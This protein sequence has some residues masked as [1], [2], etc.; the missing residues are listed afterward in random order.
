[1]ES[2]VRD[3]RFVARSMAR[4]PGFFITVIATLGLG[5][6]AT[7]AI[8]SVVN[9][10]LLRPLPYPEPERIVRVWQI[11]KNGGDVQFS[12]PNFNDVRA[13]S[14]SF[15]AMAEFTDNGTVSVTASHDAVR[16]HLATASSEF[17]S[18][19]GVRALVGRTFLPEEQHVGAAGGVVVSQGFWQRA[20]DGAPSAL[21]TV[22]TLD[23]QVYR[24]VGVMPGTVDVPTGVDL[25][26]PRELSGP[27]PHRTG[28]NYQVIAR[29]R[30]GVSLEQARR[31]TSAI[32]K[33]LKQQY[34][35]ETWMA[36][37]HLIPLREQRVGDVRP[38]LMIV[39]AASGVLLL[40]GCANVVNLLVARMASR[41]GELALRLALGAGRGRLVRQFLAESLVLSLCGGVLGV[42]I[43]AAG[44]KALLALEPGRLPRIGEVGVHWPVLLFALA[45]SV[46]CAVALGLL[47]AWRAT[48]GDIRETLAQSQRTQAGAGAT[49][50]IRSALVVAQVA[51]TLVL[52]VGAGL[53]A[54]SFERLLAV[55]PGFHANNA[56]VMDVDYSSGSDSTPRRQMVQLYDELMQ[57]F[58]AIP[59]VS[60]VGSS[61]FFPFAGGSIGDGAFIV[62]SRPDE[63][64]DFAQLP[65]LLKDKSR[66]GYAEFRLASPGFFHALHIPLVSGRL[67]DDRD[68]PIAP[69]AAVINDALARKQWPNDSPLGKIIQFGN[70]DGDLRPFTVVGVVGD[71]R[72]ASLAEA[73]EPTFYAYYRQRPG[74]AGTFF[75]VLEGA[76]A[77]AGII[78]SARRVIHDLRP[79]IPPRFRTIDTILAD[80]LADRRFTLLLL[81]A[82]GAAALL[83]ATLGVYSVIS[84]LVTQRRQEIGV[85]VALGARSEDVL[86]LVLRQ[87]ASLALVGILIGAI[88]ALGL[89]RLIAGLLYGVSATDPLSFV[90]VMALLTIVALMA[91]FIPARRAAKVDPM[92]V[93]RGS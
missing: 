82:F 11:N 6:G 24:V 65:S 83:L 89:T 17:F 38:A 7:T 55:S 71:I 85:R 74:R 20:L 2:F 32:A 61:N 51:L 86:R 4:T 45:V 34:G 31:E 80:S 67:F 72:E 35:D 58:A 40:I 81:G 56:V 57:R 43:G 10:V 79:D 36:D 48:R 53:L 73:P 62:M 52:L 18:I 44:V 49:Q 22:L 28:H 23:G 39:L 30:D 46:T 50:R 76:G 37:A 92:T 1:M 21:G 9:G 63:K 33:S 69:P 8:F 12:D 13:E 60:D 41:Q 3:L 29:L 19:L 64:I 78:A 25:W 42:L 91:T 87:G 68:G 47:T 15:G 5:I 16:A 70:M 59:G 54:R 14:R 77:P 66:S 84:F 90:A 93:L 27:S 88:A 75:F 26:I